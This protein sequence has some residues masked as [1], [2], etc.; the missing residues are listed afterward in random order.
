MI[1]ILQFVNYYLQKRLSVLPG[2]H[3]TRNPLNIRWRWNYW[4]N[5]YEEIRKK[6]KHKQGLG[7]IN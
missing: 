2:L 7:G 4:V 5:N 3:Q 6:A 1:R